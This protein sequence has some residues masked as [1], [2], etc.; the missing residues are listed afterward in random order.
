M[1]SRGTINETDDDN[2]NQ[3]QSCHSVSSDPL[4]ERDGRAF[5]WKCD[6]CGAYHSFGVS[7]LPSKETCAQLVGE[8]MP[9]INNDPIGLIRWT[10]MLQARLQYMA[11]DAMLEARK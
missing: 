6:T 3:C 1:H 4:I 2:P 7:H 10:M 8:T 11:A 5:Y 9:D